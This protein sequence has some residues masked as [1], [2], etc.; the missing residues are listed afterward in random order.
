MDIIKFLSYLCS[1]ILG[2]LMSFAIWLITSRCKY[3]VPQL[4]ISSKI[5][6]RKDSPFEIK[7]LN[8]SHHRAI[9][10]VSIYAMYQF[11][12]KNYYES[13]LGHIALLK[14]SPKRIK[15]DEYDTNMQTT[16]FELKLIIHAPKRK[17]TEPEINLEEFLCM[18]SE[19]G[20]KGY[21]DV[22][23]VCYDS[24]FGSARRVKTIRYTSDSIMYNAYFESGSVIPKLEPTNDGNFKGNL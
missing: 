5:V 22:V 3:F 23:I 16:P 24:Y 17:E 20:N 18:K 15:S 11:A 9:Y 2:G 8:K 14:K 1:T 7:I 19:T 13:K 21:V 6:K 12:S 10:D 4:E